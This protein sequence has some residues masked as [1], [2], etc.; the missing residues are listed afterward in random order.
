MHITAYCW[1]VIKIFC[2]FLEDK[3]YQCE[4]VRGPAESVTFRKFRWR[5]LLLAIATAHDPVSFRDMKI[6]FDMLLLWYQQTSFSLATSHHLAQTRRSMPSTEN[7]VNFI[8]PGRSVAHPYSHGVCMNTI[9]GFFNNWK[10]TF[11][12]DYHLYNYYHQSW[13]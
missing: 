7:C 11:P 10:F 1:N 8:F 6:E 3:W 2:Y 5:C 9:I 12:P 13:W 4:G